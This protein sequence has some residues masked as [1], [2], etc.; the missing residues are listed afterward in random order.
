MQETFSV[1]TIEMEK[2]QRSQPLNEYAEL[3]QRIKDKGLLNKQPNYYLYNIV[4]IV[5]ALLVGFTVLFSINNIW[6]LIVDAVFLAIVLAQV[7]FIGHDAGHKQIFATVRQNEII[8]MLFGNLLVGMSNTWW[9]GK[10]NEHHS[11]PNEIDMDPDLNIP[12]L[13]F[14][15][16]DARKTSGLARFI[17]K[18]QSYLFF[19]MLFFVAIDMKRVSVQFLLQ[20][21][22][23]IKNFR[24][25]IVLSCIH[26]VVP[27]ALLIW[28]LGF[29]PALLFLVINQGLLGFI[30]GSAFAPNHKGMPMLAKGTKMDFLRKQVLTARNIRASWFADFWY[31]G[32]NYQ[33][34]HHLFP[35]MPRPNL[36]QA[37]SIIK[38]YCAEHSISFAETSIF[39]SYGAILHV[40]N[41]VSRAD[42][43]ASA[44]AR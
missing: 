1:A 5:V 37:Q 43:L 7:G 31:G 30:L 17:M 13:C 27:T 34:E 14:T 29:W 12:F 33:I 6:V 8:G 10:H 35:S 41:G 19:P 20:E 28:R 15:A 23:H 21:R 9:I 11:H 36:G 25:E 39:G 26:L 44:S 24:P 2:T 38:D 42:K 3:K 4:G 32:L 22:K 16:E 18:Y 40:L